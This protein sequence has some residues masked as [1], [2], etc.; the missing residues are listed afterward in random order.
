ME[1]TDGPL[2]DTYGFEKCTRL[3]F[4]FARLVFPTARVA[5]CITVAAKGKVLLT[6]R[7]KFFQTSLHSSL[8]QE[9][10]DLWHSLT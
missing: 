9:W 8:F 2:G 4:D 5:D 10:K 3:N 1:I 7:P 6:S